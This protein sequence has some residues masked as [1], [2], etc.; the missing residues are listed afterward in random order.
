MYI[1]LGIVSGVKMVF[2]YGIVIVVF[3]LLLKVVLDIVNKDGVIFMVLCG[4]I[5]LVLVFCFF[6]VLLYYLVGIFEVYFILGFILFL[7][8]GLV[9]VVI[10]LVVGLGIQGLL[11]VF[12]DLLQFVMNIIILLVLFFVMSVIV[13][14]IILECMCYVDI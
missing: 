6:Q 5:V 8:F 1:E 7:M 14:K 11:F 2:S 9:L 10:G 4:V 3:G 12:I 13:K